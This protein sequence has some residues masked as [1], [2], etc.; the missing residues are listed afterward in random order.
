MFQEKSHHLER[1]W[2]R[3]AA[4]RQDMVRRMISAL[5]WENC[6]AEKFRAARRCAWGERSIPK[7]PENPCYSFFSAGH[8]DLHADKIAVEDLALCMDAATLLAGGIATR[9][10]QLAANDSKPALSFAGPNR[11][12][13]TTMAKCVRLGS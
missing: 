8:A 5:G 13:D 4:N 2:D 11:I 9:L 6:W 7:K 12:I 3:D 10:K 1:I